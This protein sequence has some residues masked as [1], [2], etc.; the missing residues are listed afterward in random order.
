[1]KQKKK[2]ICVVIP[3]LYIGGG[4]EKVAV[5]LGNQ[6]QNNY[7]IFYFTFHSNREEIQVKNKFCL[8]QSLKFKSLLMVSNSYQLAKFCKNN[9]IDFI[10]SHMER[11][12]CISILSKKLFRNN[13]EIFCVN[14]NY[15]YISSIIGKYF[16]KVLY[17]YANAIACVSKQSMNVLKSYGLK[18]AITIYNPFPSNEIIEKGL[19]KD[20]DKRFLK[21]FENKKN[22]IFV[23]IGRLHEQKGQEYLINIFSLVV[24]KNKN[25]KLFIFGEGELRK[26]LEKL[27]KTLQLEQHVFLM[28]N[29]TNVFKYLKRSDYFLLTSLWEGL[30]TVLIEALHFSNLKIFSTDCKSGPREILASDVKLNQKLIFPHK[31]KNGYLFDAFDLENKTQLQK[32][33]SLYAKTILSSLDES[34]K[35]NE[36]ELETFVYDNFNEEVIAKK[37]EKLLVKN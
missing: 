1:M 6:L 36:K 14:H 16:S 10:I 19:E 22:T 12:N 8:N 34:L 37:W 13:V 3:D 35:V 21:E 7:E 26:S 15:K 32:Q 17:P 33:I 25:A 20:L 30:P 5:R 18:N 27:V 24:K 29:T 31:T 28:G 4:A 23:N 9:N 11:S 2:R